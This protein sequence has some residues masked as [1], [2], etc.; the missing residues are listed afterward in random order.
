MSMYTHIGM[1]IGPEIEMRDK[2]FWIN[3]MC[4]VEFAFW[5]SELLLHV[6]HVFSF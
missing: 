5:Y 4:I 2:Q 3:R 6:L 1:Y